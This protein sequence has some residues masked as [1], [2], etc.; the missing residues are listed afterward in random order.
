MLQS[1]GNYVMCTVVRPSHDTVISGDLS[2]QL[3]N[4]TTTIVNI[5]LAEVTKY[6]NSQKT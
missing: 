5:L 1:K 4:T 3:T 6:N 2:I